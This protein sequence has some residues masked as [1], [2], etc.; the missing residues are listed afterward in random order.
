MNFSGNGLKIGRQL[1]S[2]ILLL[3]AT[4][5]LAQ[6]PRAV[7][8]RYCK[9]DGSG[10]QLEP[11][12]GS[13]PSGWHQLARMFVLEDLSSVGAPIAKAWYSKVVVIK[14]YTIDGPTMDGPDRAQLTVHYLGLGEIDPE[15]LVFSPWGKLP[16]SQSAATYTLLWT[17]KHFDLNS[18]GEEVLATSPTSWKIKGLPPI[19]HVTVEP[20]IRYVARMRDVA[21]K[22][23]IKSNANSTIATLNALRSD[24]QHDAR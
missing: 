18:N 4:A 15:S 21:S 14:G 11:P 2:F 10:K 9:L 13:S 8:E 12:N 17:T 16:A 19:P 3:S 7:L 22:V 20:A 1:L 24:F 23:E 6:S 5:A